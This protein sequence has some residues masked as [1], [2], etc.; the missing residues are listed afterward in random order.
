MAPRKAPKRSNMEVSKAEKKPAEFFKVFNPET[1][2]D[3]LMLPVAW[4]NEMEGKLPKKAFL[5]DRYGN[6]WQVELSTDQDKTYF[7][8]GWPAFIKQND[9]EKGDF[10][11]F[12]FDGILVFDVR[13]LG[14]DSCDKRGVGGLKY[15]LEEV[16]EQEVPVDDNKGASNN[17]DGKANETDPAF[18]ARNGS[19]D[20]RGGNSAKKSHH[21]WKTNRL[22]DPFGYELFKFRKV[23]RPRDPHFVA[24]IKSRRTYRMI[25]P[26]EIINAYRLELPTETILRDPRGR[27]WNTNLSI[28]IDGRQCYRT[29]WR[30]LCLANLI[31]PYEPFICEFVKCEERGLYIQVHMIPDHAKE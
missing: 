5:R 11:I 19:E 30:E 9:L 4:T 29:G 24:V 3:K 18:N 6:I 31:E 22:V 28:W 26:Q 14:I 10:I 7:H 2:S 27:E 8:Q 25:V 1:S 16:D 12:M 20:V 23:A 15:K 17:V 13:L 21:S